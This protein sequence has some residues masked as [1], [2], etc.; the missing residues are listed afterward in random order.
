MEP[1]EIPP[2]AA[3]GAAPAAAVAL[4]AHDSRPA[5]LVGARKEAFAGYLFIS[6]PMLLFAFLSIGL[7]LFALYISVWNW[8]IRSGPVAFV[9]LDNYT[10]ILSAPLFQTAVK[11]TVYY[12]IIWVPLAMATGLFLAIIVNQTL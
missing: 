9:G 11:N 3:R 10:R 8:N 6:I 12:A 5:G 7:F 4:P 2:A 1:A